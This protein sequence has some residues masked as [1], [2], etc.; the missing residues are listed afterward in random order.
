LSKRIFRVAGE[1]FFPV[2]EL[3]VDC[4]EVERIYR[5]RATLNDV[6][7]GRLVGARGNRWLNYARVGS[8]GDSA[9]LVASG[10]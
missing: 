8:V 7:A 9:L 4:I 1:S 10:L 2:R 6:Y 3:M 5:A